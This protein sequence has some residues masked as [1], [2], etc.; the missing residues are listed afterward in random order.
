MKE[1]EDRFNTAMWDFYRRMKTEAQYNP[2]RL[3]DMLNKHGGLEAA[4]LLLHT[5]AVSEGYTALWERGRLDLT[6]EAL[7]HDHPE[8]YPLFTNEEREMAR[9]R[10]E[11]YRYPPVIDPV[12]RF[13][14]AFAGDVPGWT[15]QVDKYLGQTLLEEM[16]GQADPRS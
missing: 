1:L 8:Y 9:K 3:F 13:I 14:G 11:E 5:N 12:E 16:R 2:T 10:L 6:V 7:I 15:T 4:K